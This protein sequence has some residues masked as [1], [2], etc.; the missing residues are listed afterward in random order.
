MKI[1]GVDIKYY[2]GIDI[3]GTKC[4]VILAESESVNIICKKNFATEQPRGYEYVISNIISAVESILEENNVEASDVLAAGISCG[5]PLDSKNGIIKCP[6]NLPDWDDVPVTQ[7][8]GS[9]FGFPV[10]LQNDANACALAEWKY[11]AGRGCEN[12]VF[13][14]FG[15]GMGAGLILDGKLYSGTNDMAGEVGHMRIEND[16]PVGYSKA[17]SFEGFCSGGGIARTAQMA[18]V[19][20]I[21]AGKKSVLF[22]NAEDIENITA[23]SLAVAA[24]D[25]DEFAL[26]IYRRCGEKLGK[27]LAIIIDILNPQ[28]IVIGSIY[29]RSGHLLRESMYRALEEEA[30]SLSYGCCE[31]VAAELG[32][33][34]GDYA[35]LGIAAAGYERMSENERNS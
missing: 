18:A 11:G 35:A 27:G 10:F 6:P 32:D 9:R 3:G 8:I 28:K 12:M 19:K 31:I 22:E 23:K 1:G 14:T 34:I 21:E 26:G 15:T 7:I 16:G 24:D 2:L 17:G 20:Y 25:G 33:S 29:E 4:A 5:G 30:L 13:L